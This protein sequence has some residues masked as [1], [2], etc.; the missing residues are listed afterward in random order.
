MIYGTPGKG[1]GKVR[2]AASTVTQGLL[3]REDTR[4]PY[5][6]HGKWTTG[7]LRSTLDVLRAALRSTEP[8]PQESRE[9][10]LCEPAAPLQS[11]DTVCTSEPIGTGS[12][13][14]E[15]ERW[16]SLQPPAAPAPKSWN[17]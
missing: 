13:K 17:F 2:L 6:F 12:Q 16:A 11:E 7:S 14:S 1:P 9:F 10:H 15:I 5:Q 4:L 8:S 3:E